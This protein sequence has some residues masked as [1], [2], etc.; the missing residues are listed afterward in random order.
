MKT[1]KFFFAAIAALMTMACTQEV[2]DSLTVVSSEINVSYQGAE[3]PLSFNSNVS[4]TIESDKDWVTFDQE[5]GV[6]GDI[7]VILTIAPNT[8]YQQRTATVLL[9]AGAKVTEFVVNQGYASEFGSEVVYDFDESAQTIS[10]AVDSNIDYS[11]EIS[12]DASSWISYTPTKAAPVASDIVLEISANPGKDRSGSVTITADNYSQRIVINQFGYIDMQTVDA[13]YLGQRAYIYDGSDYPNFGE[14]YLEFTS[15]E[16]NA[17]TL[18]LN[19][20]DAEIGT[21]AVPVGTYTV[22]ASATHQDKTFTLAKLDG[23]EAYYTSISVNGEEKMII[24]GTVTVSNDGESYKITTALYDEAGNIYRYRYVG[25]IASIEDDSF[26]AMVKVSFKGQY[27]TYY[28]TKANQWNLNIYLTKNPNCDI[29]ARYL[30][31]DLYAPESAT[32]DGGLPVGT[33]NFATPEI[34]SEITYANGKLLAEAGSLVH[35]YANDADYN[36]MEMLEGSKITIS[37]NSD[38]TYNFLLA[39]KYNQW[40]YDDDWNTVVINEGFDYNAEIKNVEI[41]SIDANTNPPVPDGDLEFTSA[42]STQYMGML[43]GDVFNTGGAVYTMGFTTVNGMHTVYLTLHQPTEYV[44]EK[45]F[46]NR[47]CSNP[48]EE[49]TFVFSREPKAGEKALLPVYKGKTVYTY[50]QNGYSGTKFTITGGSVTI[51]NGKIVYNL[52]STV[53]GVTY[54]F[55]GTHAATMYYV[56]DYLSSASTITIIPA[57]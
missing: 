20:A 42:M 16:G 9:T 45:N 48:L 10:F 19:V 5:S 35:S 27:Q 12:E 36:N 39:L 15:E 56:R 37:K 29:F 2:V 18:A 41:G 31:L 54:K 49:G 55:T 28:S 30:S 13:T 22:D 34:S 7:D 1:L 11:V 44:Y 52:E 26:G 38:G 46:N 3:Y 25:A 40:T 33:F 14:Y 4:W 6:A 17:M 50:V 47:Y 51:E 8:T 53:D 43:Y 21:T 23:S 32:L 24:D 57:E